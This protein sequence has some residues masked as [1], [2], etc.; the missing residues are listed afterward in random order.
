MSITVAPPAG[1]DP[2]PARPRKEDRPALPVEISGPTT[3]RTDGILTPDA[4]EFLQALHTRFDARRHQLMIR[5]MER[6][7]RFDAGE[8]PDFLHET[9][10]VRASGWRVGALAPK[11]LER[12]IEVC[13][14]PTNEFIAP[15][16]RSGAPVCVL[17]FEDAMAPT[18][19]RLLCAQ[20]RLRAILAGE[21]GGDTVGVTV[22]PR[23][24]HLPEAHVRIGGAEMSGALFD[25]GLAAFHGAGA[26]ARRGLAAA[27]SLPKL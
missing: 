13:G 23:G 18:F 8:L 22:R 2:K 16:L 21:G 4:L 14:P 27:F 26:L 12:H 17:D 10:H 5:R 24:W 25:F 20:A 3:P 1:R 7:A 15:A 9:R 11:F 6:Q 19:D